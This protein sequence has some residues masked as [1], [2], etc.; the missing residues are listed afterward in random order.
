MKTLIVLGGIGLFIIGLY[1]ALSA[2]HHPVPSA[3]SEPGPPLTERGR[4]APTSSVEARLPAR[5]QAQQ[6]PAAVAPRPERHTA[7]APPR[8]HQLKGSSETI[9]GK[10]APSTPRAPSYGTP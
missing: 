3:A 4:A 7:S 1:L 9:W 10:E 6:R 5:S 2:T 8:A